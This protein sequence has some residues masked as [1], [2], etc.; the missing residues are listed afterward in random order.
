MRELSRSYSKGIRV[1]EMNRGLRMGKFVLALVIWAIAIAP[2]ARADSSTV[3]GSY[4]SN[5]AKP[6][7]KVNAATASETKALPAV[8]TASGTLPFTG[9]DLTLVAVGG[10]VLVG[11]GLGLRKMKP[12]DQEG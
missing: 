9:S 10:I 6:M 8:A 11:L 7:I 2:A 4:V 5:A 1:V 3:L 12:E